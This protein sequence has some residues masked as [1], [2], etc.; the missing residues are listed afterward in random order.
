VQLVASAHFLRLSLLKAAHANL[1]GEPGAPVQFLLG[2]ARRP[3]PA[4]SGV[5]TQT[6]QP[7]F[8]TKE[9]AE[10][11]IFLKGTAYLAAESI[12]PYVNALQ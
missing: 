10:K 2:S 6:L 12:R 9:L 11:L 1:F 5:L 3:A 4:E 7:S 8:P